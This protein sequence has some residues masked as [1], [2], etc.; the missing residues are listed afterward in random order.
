MHLE[1]LQEGNEFI[2]YCRTSR[3]NEF[4]NYC[5]TFTDKKLFFFVGLAEIMTVTYNVSFL[6]A[7]CSQSAVGTLNYTFTSLGPK[8]RNEIV[9]LSF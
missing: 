8:E 1:K 7:H 4:I 9:F 5:R 6:M 3:E 2:N